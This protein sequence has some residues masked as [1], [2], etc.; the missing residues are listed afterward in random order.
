[1]YNIPEDL[2]YTKSHEWVKDIGN[3][4]YMMGL[5]DYAAQESGEILMVEAPVG[6]DFKKEEAFGALEVVKA[7][8]EYYAPFD[9]TVVKM[10]DEIE[11]NPELINEDPYG[12]GWIIT[13]RTE[14]KSG[15]D[16][17]LT[18]KEYSALIGE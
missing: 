5:T 16:S 1:M 8:V 11:D 9:C 13:I 18:A 14:D 4:E 3:G 10:N 7:D 12:T 2:R 6:D 17:L 15:F